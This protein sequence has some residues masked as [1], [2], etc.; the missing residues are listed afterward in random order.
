MQN[1]KVTGN[2]YLAP[3]REGGEITLSNLQVEGD[4]VIIAL[5]ETTVRLQD[6]T[7]T[8]WPSAVQKAKQ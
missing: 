1:L 4:L 5:Q 7:A 8:G 3:E 2:L 6:V